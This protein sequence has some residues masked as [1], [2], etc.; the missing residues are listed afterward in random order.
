MLY[1][2]TIEGAPRTKK[3]SNRVIRVGGFTRVLPSKAY[4]KWFQEA[5]RFG[6]LVKTQLRSQGL[7][8]PVT[9]PVRVAAVFYCGPGPQGDLNG[10]EQGLADWMQAAKVSKSGK[11]IRDGAGII[12]DDKLIAS[13][14]GSYVDNDIKN[15]RIEVC[16]EVPCS[17]KGHS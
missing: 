1:T 13:W 4:M 10:Y 17:L 3:T 11:K 7:E 14:D 6:I 5:M 9:A 8:M 15:P 16:I 2:F 12:D